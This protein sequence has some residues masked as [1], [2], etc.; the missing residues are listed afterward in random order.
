MH[1]IQESIHINKLLGV[2][3]IKP[4]PRMETILKDLYQFRPVGGG[5][6]L[7][8]MRSTAAE[9][10]ETLN[11]LGATEVECINSPTV[12]LPC[13]SF[14]MAAVVDYTTSRIGAIFTKS[15][16]KTFLRTS[17]WMEI[18]FDLF[19]KD[20]C[21][22]IMTLRKMDLPSVSYKLLPTIVPLEIDMVLAK[23]R[24]DPPIYNPLY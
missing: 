24:Y 11:K 3:V 6:L 14:V 21:L 8:H 7:F 12:F 10:S 18:I 1:G 19:Q 9:L 17:R 20:P 23:Q 4:L 2:D 13:E 5:R 16:C 22:S 15:E